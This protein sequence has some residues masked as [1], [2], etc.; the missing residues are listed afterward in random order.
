M[1]CSQISSITGFAC[2]PVHSGLC[3]QT[4]YALHDGSGVSV[5]VFTENNLCLITD[6]GLT[7]FDVLTSSGA[8]SDQAAQLNAAVNRICD[9]CGVSLGKAGEIHI[10]AKPDQVPQSFSL[11]TEAIQKIG[12]WQRKQTEK[13][14]KGLLEDVQFLLSAWR[15]DAPVIQ[16]PKVIGS[17]GKTYEFNFLQGGEFID[18]IPSTAQAGAAMAHKLLD[19]R[20]L[21]AN[22][23]IPI[24][25]VLDDFDAPTQRVQRESQVL[26]SLATI[27]NLSV[28]RKLG[29]RSAAH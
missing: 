3:I 7:L 28:L 18:A 11:I 27:T 15:P 12:I 13:T 8:S 10:Y 20:N 29:A 4:P 23:E 5:F 9:E 14:D 26:G 16:R 22:S 25:I 2:S 1:D 6:E 21:V 17:T 24:R 19:V